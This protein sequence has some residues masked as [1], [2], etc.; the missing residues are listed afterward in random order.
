MKKDLV[1][2]VIYVPVSH[3]GAVR[4]TLGECGAGHIG[5]YDYCSF[6]QK[7]T[8]RFRPGEGTNPHI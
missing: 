8:G 6:S 3:A 7:G 5:N 4:R 1:K 2:I